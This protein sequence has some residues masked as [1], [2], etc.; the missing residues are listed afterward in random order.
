[1]SVWLHPPTFLDRRLG[2]RFVGLFLLCVALTTTL[3][4]TYAPVSAAADINKTLSYQGRLF[5]G[6]GNVVP[7]GYYNMQFK[8]YQDG[9]GTAAN[10]PGGTLKWTETYRNNGGNNGV[11]V[12]NGFFSVQLGSLTP[13]GTSV[14]W[15]Q[16]T[17][18]LSMNIAG[19]DTTC[20]TFGTSPCAADGEMLPMKR[21]TAT[22]YALNAGKLGGKEASDFISNSTAQQA[23]NF[24]ILGTGMATVIQGSTSILS[25]VLD[26]ADAGVLSI[27]ETNATSIALGTTVGVH[28]I[29]IG[30]RESTGS[31]A[32]NGGSGGIA[33]HSGSGIV[34]RDGGNAR[35]LFG[36]SA[37]GVVANLS[38][39]G[40]FTV[41]NSANGWLFSVQES[42][43]IATNWN[44]Q[45]TVGGAASFSR[46]LTITGPT[47]SGY[48][49]PGGYTLST[50]INIQNYTLGGWQSLL[51]MG[52]TAD[53][54]STA[55]G[56]LVADARTS[57]HQATIGVLSPDENQIMGL[58]WNGST[59]AGYLAN[60]ANSLVLQGNS[61]DI[62]T[63]SNVSGNARVGIGNNASSGYALDVTG[64][65]NSS[66]QYRINGNTTLTSSSLAFSGSGTSTITSAASNA[67]SL[68]SDTTVRIG[69]GSAL[70]T[71]T[72]L[73]LDGA[74]SAP[75]TSL[76]GSMYYDTTLGK[77]QCYEQDGWGACGAA[78]DTFVTL[79]PEFA[80][81]V[82]NE[83]GTGTFSSG[84][85]SDT[86]NINDG[87]SS[88]PTICGTN[89]TYNF[90]KWTSA[91]GTAQTR[92][93]FV[94]YQ[95]P[96]NFKGFVA[97]STSLMGRTSAANT[98]VAYQIYR[99][100]SSGLTDCGSS[101]AVSSGS[102][103]TWQKGT[104]SGSADP[105]N[106][107]FQAGDSILLK[108]DTTTQS[109]GNAYVSNLN[110][111]Y[112]LN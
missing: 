33:L 7:D 87:S 19:Y 96:S 70:G 90:Y 38:T 62:L 26:R 8:L 44:S 4:F 75:S 28:S 109:N 108:I 99:N 55:R 50:A 46:G 102:Q 60:T 43:T 77:V 47:D 78:P 98:S 85:C 10:N 65:I 74:T 83:T 81:A 93:I 103:S 89:E 14:D 100:T 94:T 101:V 22:P 37:G 59:T 30:T 111:T 20:T 110:F 72:L 56:I 29:T 91:S 27:G 80:G 82:V 12:R 18:W 34:M 16:D 52:V 84:V 42:G 45:L 112:S 40:Y 105:A 57:P 54:A 69:D 51:A 106:C 17:L 107:G 41:N 71:P 9:T 25:P 63:A 35:D 66:S 95:L 61:L 5:D 3:I 86:L 11:H 36:V 79:S 97:G 21:L 32:I 68:N 49:T 15:N 64:D 6:N 39:D 58:S 31:T 48:T 24:N 2:L 13:F 104:A 1:M 88:Q 92:G 53:S 73:T 67:L 76:Y 23:A